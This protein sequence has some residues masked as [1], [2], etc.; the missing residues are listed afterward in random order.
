MFLKRGRKLKVD[1]G[2]L[3]NEVEEL[4]SFLDSKLD[5]KLVLRGDKLLVYSD[6]LSPNELK[7]L[8]NKFVYHKNL[9][10]NYWVELEG[11]VVKLRKF[12]HSNKKEKQKE[13]INPSTIKHGW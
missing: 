11:Y 8:V 13:G 4:S 7:K 5:A 1:L 9:N 12:K 2:E 6:S 3:N 10:H